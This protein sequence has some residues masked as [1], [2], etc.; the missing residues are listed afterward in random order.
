MASENSENINHYPFLMDRKAKKY[1]G[2]ID[3][4]L[5]NGV[6]IQREYPVPEEL[7]RFLDTHYEKGLK[8][9]YQDIYELPLS[10]SGSEFNRYYYIDLNAG[11]RS[12]VPL[13]NKDYLKPEHILIGL[14]FIKIFKIEGNIELDNIRDFI[15]LLFQEYEEE[16]VALIRL[17]TDQVSD[18]S[19]DRNED[20]V[21]TIIY[22]AFKKF[23]E[24]GWLLWDESSQQKRFKVLPSFER[25]REIYLPQIENIDTLITKYKEDE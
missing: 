7:F 3:Y 24:L 23:G 13:D 12:K 15:Q 21:E 10:Q 9:Y 18:K 2:K 19:S 17:I 6:H 22:T 16:K 8:Q 25:L 5:R 14:L 11:E 4:Y 1:F 20:K